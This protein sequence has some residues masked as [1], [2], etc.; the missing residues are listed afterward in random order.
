MKFLVPVDANR[1][2][3]GSVFRRMNSEHEIDAALVRRG[4]SLREYGDPLESFVVQWMIVDTETGATVW[5][6]QQNG[7]SKRA[8]REVVQ[9]AS[10]Y[11]DDP[12]LS[13]EP[14]VQRSQGSFVQEVQPMSLGE[15]AAAVQG[16][17][18]RRMPPYESP[19]AEN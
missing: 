9:G 5:S 16:N 12:L 4:R 18:I 19:K 17:L 6:V 1:P 15:I 11:E 7:G 3:D 2:M 14:M 13:D 8:G 10:P